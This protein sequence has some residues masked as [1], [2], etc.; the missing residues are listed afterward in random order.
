MIVLA[1]IDPALEDDDLTIALAYAVRRQVGA[2]TDDTP[3]AV[4]DRIIEFL[5]KGPRDD[6]LPPYRWS[7]LKP[8]LERIA[9]L[10]RRLPADTPATDHAG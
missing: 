2:G 8:R 7:T 3:E 4:E 5:M 10:A 9:D 1:G 6:R